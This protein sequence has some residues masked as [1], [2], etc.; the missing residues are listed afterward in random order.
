MDSSVVDGTDLTRMLRPQSIAVVGA[1]EKPGP[2]KAITSNLVSHY[3]GDL[4]LVN[5]AGSPLFGQRTYRSLTDIGRSVDLVAVA[6]SSRNTLPVLAA[7]LDGGMTRALVVADG[8]DEHQAGASGDVSLRGYVRDSGLALLGPNCLGYFNFVDGIYPSIQAASDYLEQTGVGNIGLVS[9]SG[10]MLIATLAGAATRAAGFSYVISSGSEFG[11]GIE[12]YL[13]WLIADSN[14]EV[15][16]LVVEGLNDGPRFLRLLREATAVG[17]PVVAFK[18]G[19]SEGGRSAV[20]AH[21]GK[22]AGDAATFEAAC[23]Q[24][25]A[26]LVANLGDF[27]ETTVAFS[28]S[29]RL[30]IG[31]NRLVVAMVSGGAATY[32]SDVSEGRD[33]ALPP[34]PSGLASELADLLPPDGHIANPLDISGGSSLMDLGRLGSVLDA[35]R[36]SDSYDAVAFLMPIKTWGGP[37]H[38]VRLH[39]FMLDYSASSDSP[40]C[41]IAINPDAWSGYWSSHVA[42]SGAL[43]LQ[44]LPRATQALAH[45]LG[46]PVRRE[47]VLNRFSALDAAPTQAQPTSSNKRTRVLTAEE[48]RILFADT[49]FPFAE[50]RHV[51]SSAAAIQ[52]SEELGYPVALKVDAPSAPHK[53]DLGLIS[54][55]LGTAE[56]VERESGRLMSIIDSESLIEA[57]LIVQKM[58]DVSTEFL[59]GLT[60]DPTF[61]PAIVFGVGGTMVELMPQASVVLFPPIDEMS[62][63]LLYRNTHLRPLL[64]GFRG[65]PAIDR[66]GLLSAMNALLDV[67]ARDA[68]ILTIDVNPLAVESGTGA[69]LGLDLLVE[70]QDS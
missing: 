67:A 33:I 68:G 29:R 30:S 25:G 32:M 34:I 15:I 31:G 3:S 52:A 17:K 26:V 42:G 19:R 51:D 50:E 63:Q 41:L 37:E 7:A 20:A 14:T 9:Q 21:T 65:A 28:S 27:I 66:S 4:F 60:R 70:V 22:V 47:S 5:S 16:A 59:L 8:F 61:G 46:W 53:T 13:E 49:S 1:S 38:I 40:V 10:G 55:G 64:D 48:S 69:L 24:S 6:L 2:G 23:E 57:T 12:D 35:L 45:I 36:R 11:F 56:G 43:A 39:S 62:L 54:L 44:D 18:L 58:A